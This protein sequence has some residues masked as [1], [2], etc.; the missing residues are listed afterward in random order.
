MRRFEMRSGWAALFALIVINASCSGKG[1][2]DTENK[3]AAGTQLAAQI[4]D[5]SAIVDRNAT[6]KQLDVAQANLAIALQGGTG[7]LTASEVADRLEV[8]LDILKEAVDNV[9]KDTFDPKVV[10]DKLGHDPVKL[11][12]WVR[13]QTMLVPYRGVLRGPVGV[14]TDRYGN[15]LDRSLLL[16]ELFRLAGHEVRLARATLTERQAREL[17]KRS[18]AAPRPS[19]RPVA[20]VAEP[21][22]DIARTFARRF[23]G[24]AE[25]IRL[26]LTELRAAAEATWRETSRRARTQSAAL[27][28]VLG[29]ALKR[30]DTTFDETHLAGVADHWWI[31][32][33]IENG[34]VD[35]DLDGTSSQSG[36]S[37]VAAA[38]VTTPEE[39]GDDLRHRVRMRVVIERAVD[40]RLEESVVLD[41]TL[42][43][44]DVGGI[45]IAL[46]HSPKA[47]PSDAD[48]FQEQDLAVWLN[49]YVYDQD[50]WTPFLAVGT[51]QAVQS[52]F[53][54][55]GEVLQLG[56]EHS[57]ARN[58]VGSFTDAFGSLGGF[59]DESTEPPASGRLTAEFL[60][61]ELLVPGQPP[62]NERRTL[63]DWVGPSVR[64][65]RDPQKIASLPPPPLEAML[66][67]A[68][69]TDILI[70]GAQPSSELVGYLVGQSFFKIGKAAVQLLREPTDIAKV[71]V[72][73]S[74]TPLPPSAVLLSL[75]LARNK[76]NRFGDRVHIT[77]PTIFSVHSGLKLDP[78]TGF[79]PWAALDIVV[80][81]VDVDPASDTDSA[82]IRLEQGVLDTNVEALL[83]AGEAARPNVA[84]LMSTTSVDASSW[85]LLSVPA[86]LGAAA[87]WPTDVR[88]RITPDLKR[89]F[90][91][92]VPKGTE[93]APAVWWRVNPSNG[94]TLGIGDRGWGQAM[95]EYQKIRLILKGL[96]I[97]G[98]TVYQAARG[99]WIRAGICL[100]GGLFSGAGVAKVGPGAGNLYATI[101]DAISVFAVW[102]SL[103]HAAASA[104]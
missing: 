5:S 48:L 74:R 43:V 100:V 93:T 53:T 18:T 46:G 65:A 90:V 70:I 17:L 10:V 88:H 99:K 91:V 103:S 85:E 104:G 79:R 58:D 22:E 71:A 8:S 23:G 51:N 56:A 29:P 50:V 68:N 76:W 64:V 72:D 3:N 80:N 81:D 75:A 40:G 95:T 67:L 39:I 4:K 20:P 69:E 2:D 38:S 12:E 32:Q 96:A 77:Q 24:D 21:S 45:R 31:Q 89:G 36:N 54:L 57:S 49:K 15:S 82:F 30:S 101:A 16:A 6:D 83:A 26:R 35:F 13:N 34:W 44:T 97:G 33:R 84:N 7:E 94:S 92:V 47:L 19:P 27:I 62:R 11:F 61:Y 63:F 102:D 78:E 41:Q 25:Q 9:P 87:E 55:S 66:D 37:L 98:C 42:R 14:L 73:A 52:S 86:R 59:S 28:E 60:D 1:E